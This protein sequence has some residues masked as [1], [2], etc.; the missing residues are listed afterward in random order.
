MT[1]PALSRLEAGGVV[2]AIPL[3]DRISIGL[4]AGLIVVIAPTPPET[5][6]RIRPVSLHI[7]FCRI[8]GVSSAHT[9]TYDSGRSS[10]DRRTLTLLGSISPITSSAF[11]RRVATYPCMNQYQSTREN[12]ESSGMRVVAA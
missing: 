8:E 1:P 6:T 11:S 3:K 12:D 7:R 2:P 5:P 9:Y 4:D 10:G